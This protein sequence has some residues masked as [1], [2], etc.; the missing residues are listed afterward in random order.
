[1]KQKITIKTG[2]VL[3]FLATFSFVQAQTTT[4][5]WPLQSARTPDATSGTG[6]TA[7]DQVIMNGDI[8]PTPTTV[9]LKHNG[10]QAAGKAVD[11]ISTAQKVTAYTQSSTFLAYNAN[12]Y[13]EYAVSAANGYSLNISN[14]SVDLGCGS[15]ANGKA[16]FYYSTNGFS[17]QTALGGYTDIAPLS[18]RQ[19]SSDALTASDRYSFSSI[20]ATGTSFKFRVYLWCSSNSSSGRNFTHSN[21]KITFTASELTGCQPATVS[22][23][24][25][26][27]ACEGGNA[28][29]MTIVGGGSSPTYQWQYSP[30]N[31]TTAWTNVVDGTSNNITYSN[32]TTASLNLTPATGAQNG[33]YRCKASVSCDNSTATSNGALFTVNPPAVSGTADITDASVAW[34]ASTTVNITGQTG[35]VQWQQSLDNTAWTDISSATSTSFSTPAITALSYFRAKVISGACTEIYSNA[36]SVNVGS[37][38]N[39]AS[40]KSWNFSELDGLSNLVW[41]NWLTAFGSNKSMNDLVVYATSAK[42]IGVTASASGSYTHRI[43]FDKSVPTFDSNGKPQYYAMGFL[44]GGNGALSVTL[45]SGDAANTGSIKLYHFNSNNTPKIAE[46]TNLTSPNTSA[47]P[48]GQVTFTYD[49]ALGAGELILAQ[50]TALQG[51]NV[52]EMSW[53]PGT[54][55]A[56]Q[57]INGDI[58]Y[59]YKNDAITFSESVDAELYTING[60]KLVACKNT[61]ILKLKSLKK[62]VYVLKVDTSKGTLTYKFIK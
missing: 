10:Y 61:D 5:T 26:K 59:C 33:Y 16:A 6:W 52:L 57:N 29:T 8:I 55:T 13:L 4:V 41:N 21:V 47:N 3:F 22:N 34:G 12:Y 32:T 2:L 18:V 31:G 14:I 35:T 23:P 17:S 58:Q 30:D 43:K 9:Y 27:Q 24:V 50:A 56:L 39:A 53:T 20:G 7:S 37:F 44:V 1:M 11:G 46:L 19:L 48:N 25:A 38:P 51:T 42:P 15:S 49:G 54:S 36:V 60:L 45:T 62:G 40:V 28:A